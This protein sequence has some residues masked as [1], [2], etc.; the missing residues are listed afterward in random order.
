MNATWPTIA[1]GFNKD[2]ALNFQ[3]RTQFGEMYYP[4]EMVT[5]HVFYT[6]L[7]IW[8]HSC[9]AELVRPEGRK[10]DGFGKWYTPERLLTA[11]ACM[12]EELTRRDN[13]LP[14]QIAVIREVVS[15]FAK[16]CDTQ[17]KQIIGER[18]VSF[19]EAQVVE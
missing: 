10:Y 9:P 8:N 2:V 12:A 3:W 19:L 15:S 18:A 6:W 16:W 5:R 13:L 11:F 1:K 4:R 7:L 14:W 17:P